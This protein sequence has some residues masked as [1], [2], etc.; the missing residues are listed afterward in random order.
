MAENDNDNEYVKNEAQ[1]HAGYGKRTQASLGHQDTMP[2]RGDG[3]DE[4][5]YQQAAMDFGCVHTDKNCSASNYTKCVGAGAT[6]F[7]KDAKVAS[8]GEER[9][10]KRIDG[11]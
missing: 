1:D 3:E 4:R 9:R 5:N 8:P 7:R 2:Y 10:A 11:S 6:S